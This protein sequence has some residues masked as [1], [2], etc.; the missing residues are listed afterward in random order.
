MDGF[1]NLS[2]SLSLSKDP[3]DMLKQHHPRAG[4]KGHMFHV[5]LS[6]SIEQL[7]T[8][9]ESPTTGHHISSSPGKKKGSMFH[10]KSS[11]SIDRG[12]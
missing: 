4:R 3:S 8:L 11:G 12:T 6:G 7:A 9:L 5:K 1:H 2:P 10:L